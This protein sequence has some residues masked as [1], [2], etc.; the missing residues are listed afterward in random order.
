[1]GYPA[2]IINLLTKLYGEQQAKA[3]VAG[4]IKSEF[5]VKKGVR[6]GCII[7]PYIFNIMAE[8]VAATCCCSEAGY[9]SDKH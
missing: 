9:G 5:R 1:M 3:R 7:S 4:K 2:D 6:Q 8:M